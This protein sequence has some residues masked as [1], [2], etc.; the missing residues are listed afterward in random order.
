MA[1]NRDKRFSI[2]TAAVFIILEIAAVYL[3]GYNSSL[4]KLWIQRSARRAQATLWSGDEKIREHFLLRKENE[5]LSKELFNA[6]E[7]LRRYQLMEEDIL[8]NRDSVRERFRYIPA[9]IVK[10]S[11]NSAHNYII[12]N[13]GANDGIKPLSAII[14]SKGVVGIIDAVD[15][16]FSYGITLNNYNMNVS[17]RIKGEDITGPLTWDGMH[18]NGATMNDIALHHSIAVG[19]TVV[20]SG[21]SAIFPPDIPIGT[22]VSSHIKNGSSINAEVRLFQDFSTLRHV[23][24]VENTMRDEIEGLEAKVNKEG[25]K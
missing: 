14:S 9:G 23:T 3:L 19:D 16:N 25:R 20:T 7:E 5:A 17:A 2:M 4:H 1:G 12:L 10:M 11:R 15:K 24:I 6:Q 22:I 21:F 8:M 13:K 18:S